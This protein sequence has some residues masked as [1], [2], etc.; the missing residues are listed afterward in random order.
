MNNGSTTNGKGINAIWN[1]F[2]KAHAALEAKREKRRKDK[3][4]QWIE[5]ILE[6]QRR[7]ATSIPTIRDTGEEQ[8]YR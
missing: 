7:M 4:D 1:V 6:V 3:F 5:Q 8:T 2:M